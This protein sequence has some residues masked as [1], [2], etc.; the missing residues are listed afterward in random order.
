MPDN[1]LDVK[2]SGTD[3]G[4]LKLAKSSAGAKPKKKTALIRSAKKGTKK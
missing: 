3:S 2:H 1:K 4:K